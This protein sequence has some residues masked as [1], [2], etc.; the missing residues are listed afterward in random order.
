MTELLPSRWVDLIMDAEYVECFLLRPGWGASDTS[1]P[2]SE[3]DRHFNP[4]V[5]R[6]NG[7]P[8]TEDDR[9]RLESIIL[10]PRSYVVQQS[11]GIVKTC[12]V[13]YNVGYIFLVTTER[14]DMVE[15]VIVSIC[16]RARTKKC[17][18]S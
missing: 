16:H 12:L 15:R 1:R 6:Q 4:W 10:D 5:I 13:D 8:L 17:V 2:A 3:L 18:N 11:P 14:S 9:A 7:G